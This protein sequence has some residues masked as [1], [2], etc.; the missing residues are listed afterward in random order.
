MATEQTIQQ[1]LQDYMDGLCSPEKAAEIENK[2]A[3]Q[4]EWLRE[5]EAFSD[6][7]AL[8]KSPGQM[9]EPSVRFTKNVMESIEGLQVAKPAS[10]YLNKWIFYVIA[11]LLGTSL[12]AI[13][14]VSLTQMD[15]TSE[16]TASPAFSMPTFNWEGL[17]NSKVLQVAI[18]AN[19]ILAFLLIE[20]AVSKRNQKKHA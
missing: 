1:D 9:L 3:T 4:T 13:F 18:M 2:L 5:F 6:L 8:L 12:I 15:W 20:N 11:G 10:A 17:Y 19:I 7:D 14:G 16:A